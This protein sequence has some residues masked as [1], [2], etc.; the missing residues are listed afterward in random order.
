[1]TEQ[2]K[3]DSIKE[4]VLKAIEDGR[5]KMR[6]KWQFIAKAALA[7]LGVVLVALTTLYLVSF[8]VFVLRQ[9]GVLF[10]PGFGF[11]GFGIFFLSLP[12]LLIAL[13][14][15]FMLLLEIIIKR[16][17]FAY[18]RPFLYSALAVVFLGIIGGIIIGETPL[19][20]R[21]FDEAESGHLP[22]ARPMYE[23]FGQEPQNITVGAITKITGN[24]YQIQSGDGDDLFSVIVSPQTQT[25]PPN[26]LKVGD[27]ILILGPRQ[28]KTILA[29]GIQKP[30]TLPPPRRRFV[31]PIPAQ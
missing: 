13:A 31:V 17:S 6:P 23:Y 4:G 5:V 9:T 15:L 29:Q 19:H 25:P 28:G 18:G 2:P 20:E 11:R 1:M 26:T 30:S 14:A 22:F 24:G 7:I 10:V 21:F 8:I 16:Y 27:I 12:W 3:T